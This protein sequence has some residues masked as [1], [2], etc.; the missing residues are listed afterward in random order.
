[1]RSAFIIV[2]LSA[3]VLTAFNNSSAQLTLS[4]SVRKPVSHRPLVSP[5]S[6]STI[7]V[8]ELRGG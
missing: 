2:L 4:G 3:L 6:P 7:A 8:Q 1:M 5:M